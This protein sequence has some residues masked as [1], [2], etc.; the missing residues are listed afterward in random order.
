MIIFCFSLYYI[1]YRKLV[2]AVIQ[3][4]IAKGEGRNLAEDKIQ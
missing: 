4:M 1:L 2:N 3:K